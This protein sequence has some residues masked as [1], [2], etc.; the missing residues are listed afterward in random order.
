MSSPTRCAFSVRTETKYTWI[1]GLA[2]LA[3]ND[4]P[5]IFV[6]PTKACPACA[7]AVSTGEPSRRAGIQRRI[8]RV[9]HFVSEERCRA[10]CVCRVPS[11]LRRF[12]CF[13]LS[14]P[15]FS[16][17]QENHQDR[18][19]NT[20]Q[21]ACFIHRLWRAENFL[22]TEDNNCPHQHNHE[23]IPVASVHRNSLANQIHSPRQIFG[24]VF[25]MRF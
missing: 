11:H 19:P 6:I 10:G 18:Y 14:L 20:Q 12:L 17:F 5:V 1:T 16:N 4:G 21:I 24:N 22:E 23:S 2:L 8:V 15:N 7:S 3:R 25:L 9:E 13:R